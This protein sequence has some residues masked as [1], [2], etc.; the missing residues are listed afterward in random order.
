MEDYAQAR[1]GVGLLSPFPYSPLG[2]DHGI[3]F[4]FKVRPE[5]YQYSYET[6]I[7]KYRS[8]NSISD[9]QECTDTCFISPVSKNYR[10]TQTIIGH[11]G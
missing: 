2:M 6:G 4:S 1:P 7:K 3:S 5:Y 9:V 10:F 11:I 8:I